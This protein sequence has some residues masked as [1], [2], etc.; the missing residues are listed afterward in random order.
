MFTLLFITIPIEVIFL[1]ILRLFGWLQTPFLFVALSILFFCCAVRFPICCPIFDYQ[2]IRPVFQV[3]VS[4]VTAQW[5]TVFLWNQKR[6]PDMYALPLHSALMDLVGQL[7][8]VVC[9]EIASSLGAH[10]RMRRV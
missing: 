5:L 8:L 6:D 4:L 10:V 1:A 3:A 7:L 9:F 2:L